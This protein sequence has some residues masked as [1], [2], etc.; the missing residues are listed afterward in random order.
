MP[1]YSSQATTPALPSALL[2]TVLLRQAP[3]V[4]SADAALSR[5]VGRGLSLAPPTPA[6][7][8]ELLPHA[9]W[10]VQAAWLALHCAGGI[11]WL[12][13]GQ[14]A[15]AALTGIDAAPA[16]DGRWPHWMT[17][18]VAGRLHGSV[19]ASLQEVAVAEPPSRQGM[20][21]LRMQISDGSHTV[22][23][24]GAAPASLWLALLQHGQQPARPRRMALAP[25][26]PAALP[27]VVTLARHRLPQA[28]FDTLA[29]GDVLLPDT[30]CFD[31]SGAGTLAL[32]GRRWRVRY[33]GARA[34]QLLNPEDDVDDLALQDQ[35]DSLEEGDDRLQGDLDPYQDE[36]PE[37]SAQDGAGDEL[38]AEADGTGGTV[39]A[40]S[41]EAGEAG[42]GALPGA[43]QLALRFELGRL[44]LSLERIRALG[45]G[46]VL[47]LLDGAPH[48]IAVTCT[49]IVVGRGEVVD[50][51]GRLGVRLTQWSGAC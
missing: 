29:A 47:E 34:L 35:M 33:Q 25:W 5:A 17:G 51:D 45:P 49:G 12:H 20:A 39:S 38:D 21:L 18:A 46:C 11:L 50:V 26:L 31:T 32:A 23:A 9:D 43:I 37:Q 28:D 19:L 48:S 30:T 13:Q 6:L 40:R 3:R 42:Q 14:R 15:L 24:V 4:E 36:D 2:S 1:E 41:D 27:V 44:S 7:H 10:P 22:H 8:W 16:E